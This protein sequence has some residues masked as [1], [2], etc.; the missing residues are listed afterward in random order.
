MYYEIWIDILFIVN[1]WIDFLLLRLVNHLLCGTATPFR[2]M[3]GACIGAFVVCLLTI[4]PVSPM[5]NTLLVHVVGNTIMVRFGCNLKTIK[6]ICAGVL[7]L[8]GTTIFMGGFLQLIQNHVGGIK[9]ERILIFG[10]VGYLAFMEGFGMYKKY[11]QKQRNTYRAWLYANG[12]CK[13]MTAFLDT[14]NH[15][16][17]PFSGKPVCIVQI[18]MLEG[19]CSAKTIERLQHFHEGMDFE[20]E[21][22]KLRPHYVPFSSLGCSKGM[23]L[24]VTM[25]FLCLENQRIQKVITRPVIAFSSE[26]SSFLGNYQ[27]ILHPNLIDS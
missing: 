19:L 14:G 5:V 3:V 17:D 9:I 25:D 6:K 4:F 12:K 2:S 16:C 7:L 24:A 23:A 11:L 26:N 1:A 18:T 22:T 10:V 13:E 21:T 15:L 20:E 8:Y 27:M